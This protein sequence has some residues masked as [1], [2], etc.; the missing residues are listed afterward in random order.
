MQQN[1]NMNQAIEYQISP[2]HPAAHVFR[3]TL[4][5]REPDP[6][7]QQLVLPAWIPGSYMIRDFARNILCVSASCEGQPVAL[8]KLDKHSWQA[9]PV[10]GIL[11]VVYEVYAWDLSVR[12]AHLDTTHGFFN[13]TSVFLRV[14]GQEEKPLLV[15]LEPPPEGAAEGWRVA[16]SMPQQDVDEAGFG[17]YQVV[18]YAHLVDYPVEMGNFHELGF[19]VANVPH[20]MV[21]TGKLLNLDNQRLAD[22][23]AAICQ[24]HAGMFGELPIDRYLFLTMVT[25]DGYGGLEHLDSTALMCKRDDLPYPGM[26]KMN[27]DYRNYLGLCSH[28]YFHLWNVKRI[29]PKVLKEADLSAEVHTELLWAFE[30]I[31]SYYD[32]LALVRSGCIDAESYLELLATTITRVMRGSGRLRQSVA[33]S[34]FDTWTRFYKQD[35]NAPNAIVSYYSKGA[36]VAL[37][38]DVT[39]REATRDKVSLDDFMRKLW[40]DF[41]Q[42]DVGVEE[43]DLEKLAAQL[44]GQDLGDFFQRNVHACEELPLAQ[45]LEYFAIG[46][47]LRPSRGPE[48]WGSSGR[49]GE[50]QDPQHALGA[51]YRQKGDFVELTQVYDQGPAQR[52]GLSAGDCL[53][54]L[55]GIQV[56]A[57]GLQSMLDRL[58]TGSEVRVHAFRRDELMSF[59]LPVVP[60]VADTCELWLLGEEECTSSQLRR[61]RR[62]LG[63]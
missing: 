41:G 33:E 38:L 34:S 4:S 49:S 31:T 60:P 43:G 42:P 39:L 48:D 45:W 24:Q 13:G 61:R 62:W 15:T 2:F 57:A 35:E 10:Q 30:G 40:Q 51:R 6:L 37:G 21:F 23:L 32:D 58:Q 3:V 28:E 56:S 18:D 44:A 9:A 1:N 63:L 53:L 11:V 25:G 16:T 17:Q 36:L 8:K 22:D 26:G 12:G 20:R 7:G 29:R 19:S 5:V 52:A 59:L 55:D 54:A 47:R 14:S 46:Y 27:K 50:E